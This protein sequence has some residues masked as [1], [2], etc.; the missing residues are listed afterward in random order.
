[1]Y[2]EDKKTLK[3]TLAAVEENIENMVALEGV[4]PDKIA[5][6]VMIDG[7]EKMD[8]SA[9]DFFE[10]MDRNNNIYLGNNMAPSL[11]I[12]ELAQRSLK[13]GHTNYNED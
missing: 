4:D 3:K 7:I 5:V 13:D 1:M 6:F 11:S 8:R 12:N 9:V 10:E 2:N